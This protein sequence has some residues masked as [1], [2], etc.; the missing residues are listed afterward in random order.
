MAPES[1][2]VVV[3]VFS[4]VISLTLGAHEIPDTV[5]NSYTNPGDFFIGGLFP[6]HH[7]S[8]GP[9]DSPLSTW[10]VELSETMA[11][12][13][14]KINERRDLLPK[15]R[16]G[17]DIRDDCYTE[18]MTLFS[19]LSLMRSNGRLEILDVP[20]T[21]PGEKG[22]FLGAIGPVSSTNSILSGMVGSLFQV[23]IIS[24]LATSDELSDK[25]RFPYFL[26]STPPDKLNAQAIIDLLL[27]Y[28][29]DYVA[30]IY[31]LD[32]YG[33]RG[34]HE[35][36][37]LAEKNGIC[38]AFSSPIANG[39]TDTEIDEVVDKLK[40][41]RFATV[42][43]VFAA[44]GAPYSI[45][46]KF[47]HQ[48]PGA[49]LTFI[50]SAAF[51][52]A[53]RLKKLALSQSTVG[54]MFLP[55]RYQ[56]IDEFEEYFKFINGSDASG[57]KWFAEF[58][59][60][61]L[62]QN[63]C[64]VL[65][66]C[67]P[68]SNNDEVFVVNAVNI[69]AH[70]LHEVLNVCM[71]DLP[72]TY[73]ITARGDLFLP[74]LLGVNFQGVD[75]PFRFESNGEPIG[76]YALKNVQVI[77]GE[78]RPVQVGIWD[79][80]KHNRRLVL[81]EDAVI[82]AGNSKVPPRSTCRVQCVPGFIA[83]PLQEKCCWGCQR[84]PENA[85]TA[86]GTVCEECVSTHW[87]NHDST[88][89]NA[90]VPTATTWDSPPALAVLLFSTT[91]LVLS[92]VVA[93]GMYHYRRHVII[94]SSSRELS[95]VQTVGIV[96]AY[97]AAIVTL[98]RP[99]D[100]ACNAKVTMI[101]LS[102]TVT[103]SATLLKVIR[104]YRIFK[105]AKKSTKRPSFVSPRVQIA[106]AS[107]FGSVQVVICIIGILLHSTK[108]TLLIPTPPRN[109][110]DLFC[111]LG[112]AFTASCVYNLFLILACC[113]FA[114]MAR[115]VPSNYNESKFIAAN[116]YST[117]VFCMAALPVYITATS[118]SQRVV[119]LCVVVLLNAYSTLC[120]AFMP[121]LYAARFL[122]NAALD[123]SQS[124]GTGVTTAGG[125]S[126][127]GSMLSRPSR[128]HPAQVDV[129]AEKVQSTSKNGDAPTE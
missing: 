88:R 129:P 75:G 10:A 2:R 113:Y 107:T 7:S 60:G 45:L 90:I 119:T 22:A 29:W 63:N 78:I 87:P 12:T 96:L 40:R 69:F 73:N 52:S 66:Q 109:H 49:N 102:F 37:K 70:A 91:G 118:A 56:V 100:A 3:V 80:L 108:P 85:I 13:V 47:R 36:Q 53:Y 30:L 17:F 38:L 93:F 15:I 62:S 115:K 125:R 20:P 106:A 35:V 19:V 58:Q 26:R 39:A 120:L 116:V 44:S 72:C 55:I 83:V 57:S 24:Y 121:K 105:V 6:F 59:R 97:A 46:D 1:T 128:V 42:V 64:S 54:G 23:P 43:I 104:I 34:A 127:G 67:P 48:V 31:S 74:Y 98:A 82:W 14:N 89:C 112:Y 124:V 8:S 101:S 28:R 18:S 122:K 103:F 32:S 86:I 95:A 21:S 41:Y 77:S 50:G 11:F 76:R 84:C 111:Q 27:H 71:G 92:S 123:Q 33:I 5:H 110:I 16:L 51:E 94:K 68:P 9:C 126:G 79:S 61:W 4:V 117:L 25:R 114:L 81:D 65:S 99:S